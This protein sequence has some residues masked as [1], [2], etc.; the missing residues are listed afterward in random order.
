MLVRR[1]ARPL[2]ASTFIYGGIDALRNPQSKA[3]AVE[4]LDI[5]NRPG[6]EKLNLASS[7]QAVKVNGAI[8]VAAGSLLALG[9]FPRIAALALAGSIVPTTLAG[10]RFWEESEPAGRRA[11]QLHFTKNVSML[12]GL[13]IA[14]VDTAGKES[15]AHKTKRVSRRSKRKAAKAAA[16]ATHQ[17]TKKASKRQ[18]AAKGAVLDA[19]P[20]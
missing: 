11:Q 14:S 16:K 18:A 20:G 6:I 15:L 10:H 19:L 13:L 2:L 9:R 5:I 4:K 7:E 8:Q 12:G 3:P 17:A 1:I